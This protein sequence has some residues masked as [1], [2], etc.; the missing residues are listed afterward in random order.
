MLLLVLASCIGCPAGCSSASEDDTAAAAWPDAAVTFSDLHIRADADV[1]TILTVSWTTEPATA[2]SLSYGETTT[3]GRQTATETTASKTHSVVVR[4]LA[5]DTTWHFRPEGGGEVGRDA[6]WTTEGAPPELPQLTVGGDPDALGG[7]LLLPIIGGVAAVAIVDS[8][9][10]YVWWHIADSGYLVTRAIPAHSGSDILYA[11]VDPVDYGP[12]GR[13]VRVPI[14]GGATSEV[15]VPYLTHDFLELPGG[16]LA[17]LTK[18]FRENYVGDRIVE[19]S[20]DGVEDT[21]AWSAFDYFN[22]E[23]YD[24]DPGDGTWTHANALDYDPVDDA[25]YVS[26]RN[27]DTILKA[28][29][30][31]RQLL[32]RLTASEPNFSY[33]DG[34]TPTDY[35]H[36]FELQPDGGLLVFDNGSADR[37]SSRAVEYRLNEEEGTVSEVWSYH[38]TPPTYVHA[39][40]SVD[41]IAEDRTLITWSTAGVMEVVAADGTQLWRL[42]VQLGHAFGYTEWVEGF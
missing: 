16:T 6:A 29:R 25:W 8:K 26:L 21:V 19:Y 33:V 14:D 13:L 41:R 31:S 40:G 15:P 23:N 1:P 3:Y 39:L 24:I 42:D 12:N 7:Y 18:D 28:D 37:A 38:S 36:K 32:W 35:Q 2:G 22:P 10:R 17:C 30:A 11:A 9:G 4:G 27:F 34:A 5:A 20:A